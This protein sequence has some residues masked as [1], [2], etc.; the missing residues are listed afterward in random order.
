MHG[1]KA[2]VSYTVCGLIA[3]LIGVVAAAGAPVRSERPD[4]VAKSTAALTKGMTAAEVL[5][6]AGRPA[7]IRPF[8]APQGKAEVWIYRR[9]LQT[10]VNQVPVVGRSA[11]IPSMDAKGA[12][13]P[14][15]VQEYQNEYITVYQITRLLMYNDVLEA[16]TQTRTQSS[17]YDR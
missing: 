4:A 8:A 1:M 12:M 2:P 16:A 3:L 5:Q 7:E 11:P 9:V 6:H 15:D 14:M 17:R 10:R 13:E